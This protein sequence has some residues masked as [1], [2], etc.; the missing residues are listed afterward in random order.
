M[1]ETYEIDIRKKQWVVN[2]FRIAPYWHIFGASGRW[3][4]STDVKAKF[5][6]VFIY[7]DW[8]EICKSCNEWVKNNCDS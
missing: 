8:K 5:L 3:S 6:T 2:N 1:K 7:N 4:Y